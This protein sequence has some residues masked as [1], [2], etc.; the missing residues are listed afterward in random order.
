[1]NSST[2][3]NKVTAALVAKS[4]EELA[5]FSGT[6]DAALKEARMAPQGLDLNEITDV[7]ATA[8]H[9][10]RRRRSAAAAQRAAAIV[11]ELLGPD[12]E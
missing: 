9:L 12:N 11:R 1:M 4:D 7:A 10:L 3:N 2:E 5:A 8:R 6:L